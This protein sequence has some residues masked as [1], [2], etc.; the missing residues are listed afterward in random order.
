M[1]FFRS[2]ATLIIHSFT[3]QSFNSLKSRQVVDEFYRKLNIS[4]SDDYVNKFRRYSNYQPR[5]GGIETIFALVCIC[6]YMYEMPAYKMLILA[7]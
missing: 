7:E 2:V 5:S 3:F 1:F 4:R 6:I